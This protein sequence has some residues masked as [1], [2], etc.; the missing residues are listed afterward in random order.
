MA[1]ACAP[2][3]ALSYR[4]RKALPA[5]AFALPSVRM[6]PLYKQ[7]GGKLVPSKTHAINAKARATQAKNRGDLSASS[8]RTIHK[9]ADAVIKECDT[10]AKTKRKKVSVSKSGRAI[11]ATL[12]KRDTDMLRMIQRTI[13]AN[14]V[15]MRDDMTAAQK[16]RVNRLM[17]R[18]L[19]QNALKPGT[20]M[21]TQKGAKAVG[22]KFISKAEVRQRVG[23]LVKAAKASKSTKSGGTVPRGRK[24]AA[25]KKTAKK[26]TAK[27]KAA[28]KKTQRTP[29]QRAATKRLVA[30]NKKRAKKKAAKK[31]PKKRAGSRARY[32]AKKG[33]KR[34]RIHVRV[35]GA[36]KRVPVEVRDVPEVK[37][38]VIVLV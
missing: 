11:P 33:Q 16:A 30:M 21:L 37:N 32:A 12:D 17:A 1:K 2:K 5:K 10:M 14:E 34:G 15:V 6:F 3:G 23:Q 22:V 18:K 20:Y 29:A 19:V 24:K 4:Q 28:K 26:K 38:K 36:S 7:V 25:K 35:S 27:K 8:A 13:R 9:R 31:K